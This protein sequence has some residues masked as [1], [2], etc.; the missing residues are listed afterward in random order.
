MTSQLNEHDSDSLIKFKQRKRL[1]A[2]HPLFKKLSADK[3]D[4]LVKL[5]FEKHYAPK[6]IIASQD[7][8]VDAIY[9]IAKGEVEVDRKVNC[10]MIPQAILRKGETI[11]LS[12]VGFFSQSGQRTATLVTLSKCVLIGW[13]LDTFHSFLQKYPEVSLPMKEAS[14]V[15][16]RISF[17]KQVEPFAELPKEQLFRLCADIKELIVPTGTFLFRKGDIGNECYLVCSGEVAITIL[18]ADGTE[19][20]LASV[21]PPMLFG[22]TALLTSTIRNANAKM[23]KEGKLLVIKKSQL[24]ELMQHH[25]T[26]ESMMLL[27]IERSRPIH[28]Q[29]IEHYHRQSDD[30][31]DIVILKDTHN[32]RYFQ[33]SEE[34]WFI[35]QHLDGINTLQDLSVELFKE[36]RVFCPAAIADTIFNLSDAGFVKLPEVPVQFT[37]MSQANPTRIQKFGRLNY[38]EVIFDDIDKRLTD[39]YEGGIHLLYTLPGR[40]ILAAI[41]LFGILSFGFYAPHV[42]E[43]L[44]SSQHWV[45]LAVM[46]VVIYFSSVTIHELAH[47]YTT[48]FFK[49]EIHRAG[50]LVSLVSFIA[51]VDT[52]DMWLSDKRSK[53]IVSIAGPIADLCTAGVVSLC[54]LFIPQKDIALFM[55]L[56]ALML[57]YSVFKNLN[58]FMEN[59]GYSIVK[60]AFDHPNLREA[61]IR[62]LFRTN[63]SSFKKRPGEIPYLL[64]CALFLTIDVFIAFVFQGYLRLLLPEVILGIPVYHLSWLLPILVVIKYILNI[65]FFLIK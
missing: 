58:P 54:A 37:E 17:I 15:L 24:D 31:Q 21:T 41:A 23:T 55:W 3:I 62:R 32:G 19:K 26:A 47:A 50:I 12:Q 44:Q 5:S 42:I 60:D 14:E 39:T 34:G 65:R 46:L 4:E 11:G 2:N 29:G 16:Q 8:A 51:Y 36:K 13:D 48:K 57:Y 22:E 59:D 52:S 28:S 43:N 56:F 18:N 49:H 9:F 6:E 30:G 63:P 33:L 64:L 25:T 61:S 38:I 20:K 53:I 1:I 45:I 10:E 35:W 40:L 7:E 27:S